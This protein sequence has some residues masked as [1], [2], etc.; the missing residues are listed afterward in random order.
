M[1]AR[2]PAGAPAASRGVGESL[3]LKRRAREEHLSSYGECVKGIG[4]MHLR[5]DWE[6]S[7]AG[8][9]DARHV[10]R[11]YGQLRNQQESQLHSRRLRCVAAL[12]LV[13]R[14]SWS[15]LSSGVC[16]WR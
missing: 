8:K 13:H 9:A 5:A 11:V 1:A 3:I 7:L 6:H 14:D 12:S 16:V 15:A 4:K 2:H 10:Q